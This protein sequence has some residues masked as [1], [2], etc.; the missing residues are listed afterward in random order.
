MNHLLLSLLLATAVLLP[1]TQATIYVPRSEKGVVDALFRNSESSSNDKEHRLPSRPADFGRAMKHKHDRHGTHLQFLP[2]HPYLCEAPEDVII[3]EPADGHHVALLVWRGQCKFLQ[4]A[5]VAQ[6]LS[7]YIKYL[8]VVNYENDETV[9]VAYDSDD[10]EMKVA[11]VTQ[12]SLLSVSSSSGWVLQQFF[13]LDKKTTVGGPLIEVDGY[14][15]HVGSRSDGYNDNIGILAWSAYLF[16]WFLS[17]ALI[18][19]MCFKSTRTKTE[20]AGSPGATNV[21]DQPAAPSSLP[22][23]T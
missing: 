18:S 15:A 22:T 20:T 10:G 2:D 14:K 8:V 11:D 5:L 1:F 19:W 21:E 13:N 3:Q 23:L 9:M 6:K 16:P 7:P 17:G 4:K 12:L